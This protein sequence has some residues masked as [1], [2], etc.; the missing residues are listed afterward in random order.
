MTECGNRVPFAGANQ[1]TKLVQETARLVGRAP[2]TTSASAA[3]VP[4]CARNWDSSA[5]C[6][7]ASSP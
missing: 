1:K 7:A 3:Y 5:R 2:S 6:G 4:R